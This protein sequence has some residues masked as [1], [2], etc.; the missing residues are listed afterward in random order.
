[1]GLQVLPPGILNFQGVKDFNSFINMFENV[2]MA[3]NIDDDD[4]KA[5]QIGQCFVSTAQAWSRI[6]WLILSKVCTLAE[7][8]NE[9]RIFAQTE[10]K[11]LPLPD[12]M[13][14]IQ[15]YKGQM[16][17]NPYGGTRQGQG[18]LPLMQMPQPPMLPAM[19]AAVPMIQRPGQ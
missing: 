3:Q 10:K 16:M 17:L 15:G 19:H 14:I 4:D 7:L 8:I 12:P 9:A 2:C 11:D 5:R 1:M 13:Y 18:H 6:N